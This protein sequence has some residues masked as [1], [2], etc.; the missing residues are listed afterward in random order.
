MK[1]I[2]QLLSIAAIALAAAAL[3]ANAAD[4]IRVLVVTG[5][6]AFEQPQ[7]FKMFEDNPE[8][9]FKAIEHPT[10]KDAAGKPDPFESAVTPDA[11]KEFDVLVLYDMWQKITDETK[12]NLIS[13]LKQGKGLL[14]LHHSFAN[15]QAWDE[16]EAIV[17]GRYFLADEVVNGV[18][19][20]RCLWKH[21]VDIPVKIAAEHPITAGLKDFTIHDETYKGYDVAPGVQVLL[22]TDEPLSS[23]EIAW[24]KT[25]EKARVVYLQLGH[26]HFAYEDPNYR[27][28]L[29]NAIRWTAGK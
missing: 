5:G 13:L 20:K 6:H 2:L 17:G 8:I 4:K 28:L 27:R 14:S 23:K 29:A 21:G 18:Q 19:K 10:G 7:F 3:P 9:T 22:T 24:A 15:Y 16:W 26:D 25:Y 12:A 1:R 11:A